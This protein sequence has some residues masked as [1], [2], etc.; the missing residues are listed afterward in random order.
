MRLIAGIVTYWPHFELLHQLIRILVKSTDGLVIFANSPMTEEARNNLERLAGSGKIEIVQSRGNVGLGVAYNYIL[1]R[2]RS[3]GAKAVFLSDQ[4]SVPLDGTVDLLAKTVRHLSLK[5]H[6]VAVV[7]PRPIG[8]RIQ[9]A[10]FKNVRLFKRP[11]N[12]SS[13]HILAADFVISS[14]SVVMLDAFEAIG[15]FR[16]D[17]FI[18]GIDIEWCF[19]AWSKG[20]SCWIALDAFMEHRLGRGVL[21]FPIIGFPVPRQPP[22]RLY[23]YVRNQIHMLGMR[24]V[25]LRWKLKVIPYIGLQAFVYALRGNPRRLSL[26][27]IGRGMCEGVRRIRAEKHD[28]KGR[29]D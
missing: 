2:A 14:G 7:G 3:L 27:A 28:S 15:P 17:F 16:E 4:D 8:P 10:E 19:R 26:V 29:L 12:V 11:R 23:T 13:P 21:T 6:R 22:S 5:G 20:F 1:K 9:S 25:P 18:D 24:H